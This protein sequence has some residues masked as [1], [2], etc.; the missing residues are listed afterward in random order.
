MEANRLAIISPFGG[1]YQRA[2]EQNAMI[3]NRFVAA[4]TEKILVLHAEP[5]EKIEKLVKEVSG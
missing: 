4:L 3:R 1:K 2:S 5:G